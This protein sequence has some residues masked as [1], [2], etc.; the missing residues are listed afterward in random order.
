MRLKVKETSLYLIVFV[1]VCPLVDECYPSVFNPSGTHCRA[2]WAELSSSSFFIKPINSIYNVNIY[3]QQQIGT[4][5]VFNKKK[6]KKQLNTEGIKKKSLNIEKEPQFFLLSDNWIN[7]MSSSSSLLHLLF[8]KWCHWGCVR[9]KTAIG[10]WAGAQAPPHCTVGELHPCG[11]AASTLSV[12]K[13]MFY[14]IF[15]DV[16]FWNYIRRW[17]VKLAQVT[18]FRSW[19]C[20]YTRLICP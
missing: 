3:I 8:Y 13:C 12:L 2:T 11:S 18:A 1:S 17:D 4:R 16:H 6:R 10:G 14:F 20:A 15:N 9:I 7:E 5:I 19:S